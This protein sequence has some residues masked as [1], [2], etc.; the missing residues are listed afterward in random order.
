MIEALDLQKADLEGFLLQDL[1]SPVVVHSTHLHSPYIPSLHYPSVQV[2]ELWYSK[3]NRRLLKGYTIPPLISLQE[4]AHTNTEQDMADHQYLQE[5]QGECFPVKGRLSARK[6]FS[7]KVTLAGESAN[8]LF[9]PSPIKLPTGLSLEHTG[10]HSTG[11][12][13]IPVFLNNKQCTSE[14]NTYSQATFH[15]GNCDCFE[16]QM[17]ISQLKKFL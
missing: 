10:N 15:L 17:S 14:G 13:N 1:G 12:L 4:K 7:Y 8:P 16:R 3:F 5:H 2:L 9:P 11:C 6:A